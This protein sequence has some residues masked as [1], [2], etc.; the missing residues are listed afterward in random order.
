M[1]RV[2]LNA[3]VQWATHSEFLKLSFDVTCTERQ[4]IYSIC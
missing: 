4:Y 3:L 1:K 2:V